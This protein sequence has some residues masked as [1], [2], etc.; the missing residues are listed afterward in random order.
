ME[1]G[2]KHFLGAMLDLVKTV[3][4]F[5]ALWFVISA[6]WNGIYDMFSR[7]W[8]IEPDESAG[9]DFGRNMFIMWVIMII[10]QSYIYSE[11]NSSES[12]LNVVLWINGIFFGIT[13]V[14]LW[15]FFHTL[16]KY[17]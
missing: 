17:N 5:F 6:G 9:E 4:L 2:I 14:G 15:Y 10:V 8:N 7:L 3:L 12:V 11:S 16:K 1:N 13:F